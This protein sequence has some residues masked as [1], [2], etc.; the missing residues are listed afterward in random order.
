MPYIY[1]DF[2]NFCTM[3]SEE[4]NKKISF[5]ISF[6]GSGRLLKG[7]IDWYRGP[8]SSS[9]S[10]GGGETPGDL[11][12]SRVSAMAALLEIQPDHQLN[13]AIV[14]LGRSCTEPTAS[15]VCSVSSSIQS[16]LHPRM[17]LFIA[18]MLTCSDR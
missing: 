10:S 4:K 9:S 17:F 2:S 6:F 8:Y 1:C 13:T 11:T 5:S 7:E 18:R 16:I 15:F 12:E 14:L 3:S